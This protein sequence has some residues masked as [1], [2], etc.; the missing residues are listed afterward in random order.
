MFEAAV[1]EAL[2]VE[3]EWVGDLA[4]GGCGA[5]AA[6]DAREAIEPTIALATPSPSRGRRSPKVDYSVTTRFLGKSSF[7]LHRH[8]GGSRFFF[9]ANC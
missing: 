1:A 4:R 8:F 6:A 7:K 9:G 2:V 3:A 5:D